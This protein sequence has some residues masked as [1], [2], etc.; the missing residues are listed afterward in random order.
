MSK[1]EPTPQAE[2]TRLKQQAKHLQDN[3]LWQEALDAIEEQYIALWKDSDP[4]QTTH[5]ENA[6]YLIL[7]VGKLRQQIQT[8]AQAGMLSKATAANNVKGK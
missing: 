2:V 8:F 6:Y 5:R 4:V 3:P 1:I 7:A